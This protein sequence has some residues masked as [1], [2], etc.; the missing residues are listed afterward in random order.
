MCLDP[1]LAIEAADKPPP[2]Y[3]CGSCVDVLRRNHAEHLVD[4]LHP[5][6][7]VSLVC[8]NKV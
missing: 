1:A 7:H 3:I 4:V 2:L 5:M 6:D 8:E